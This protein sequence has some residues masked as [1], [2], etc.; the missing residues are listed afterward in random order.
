MVYKVKAGPRKVSD[1]PCGARNMQ[2][3]QHMPGWGWGTSKPLLL[4]PPRADETKES[5]VQVLTLKL[6]Q[7]QSMLR[8][9]PDGARS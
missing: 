8:A 1:N 6:T 4:L 2:R 5:T 7:V 3:S 9:D